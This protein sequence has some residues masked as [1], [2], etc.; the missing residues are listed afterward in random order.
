MPQTPDQPQKNDG[1]SVSFIVRNVML[2]LLSICTT[3]VIWIAKEVISLDERMGKLE[4]A[5]ST[6]AD[7]VSDVQIKQNTLELTVNDLK[8]QLIRVEDLTPKFKKP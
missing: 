4:F 7:K 2:A 6:N 5:I 8:D 3:G 1:L